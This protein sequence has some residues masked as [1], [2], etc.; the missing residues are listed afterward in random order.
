[1]LLFYWMKTFIDLENNMKILLFSFLTIL[2]LISSVA[3]AEESIHDSHFTKEDHLSHR[4]HIAIF[5]GLSTNME[6]EHT[7]F[8]L[9]FDYEY[10]LPL[11]HDIIGIGIFG[12]MVFAD[13]TEYIVGVPVFL[14]PSGGLKF[15]LAPGLVMLETTQ[16]LESHTFHKKNMNKLL[17]ESDDSSME[18]EFLIRIGIGYDINIKNFSITPAL[19]ADFIN[20]HLA[21]VYGIDFGFHGF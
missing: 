11:W 15:W 5:S 7:D 2:T 18:Q 16:Q 13:H 14:H 9:G 6:H 10:R 21:L 1:M 4:N 17:S 19:S 3:F 12:E 20:G 8:S